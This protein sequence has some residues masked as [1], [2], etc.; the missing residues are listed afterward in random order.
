VLTAKINRFV[1]LGKTG[2]FYP[3]YLN[4]AL[5]ALREGQVDPSLSKH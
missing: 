2:R 4:P 5:I 1:E 3:V